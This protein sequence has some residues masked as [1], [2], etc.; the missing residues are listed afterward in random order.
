MSDIEQKE[1]GSQSESGANPPAPQ[2]GGPNNTSRLPDGRFAPPAKRER[3]PDGTFA[4]GNKAG[5]R[6]GVSQLRRAASRR[7]FRDRQTRIEGEVVRR[8]TE[9]MGGAESLSE[10]QR[11]VIGIAGQLCGR[12]DRALKAA[13]YLIKLGHKK[14]GPKGIS[15]KSL[16]ELDAQLRPLEYALLNA[17]NT[18]GLE[19]RTHTKASLS[20]YIAEKYSQRDDDSE[21]GLQ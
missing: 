6:N 11:I 1:M 13:G 4:P 5:W 20:S 12:Y 19:K 17:L 8:L 15:P 14:Y 2:N 16:A 7:D 21:E 3:L 9:D 10:A 18:L